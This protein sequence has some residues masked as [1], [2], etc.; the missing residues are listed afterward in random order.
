[1][2]SRLDDVSREFQLRVP[3]RRALKFKPMRSSLL[4]IQ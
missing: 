2:L 3:M 1:M 4:H